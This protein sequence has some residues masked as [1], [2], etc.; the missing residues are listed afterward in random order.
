MVAGVN[1]LAEPIEEPRYT[2]L[3][4]IDN[5][6]IRRYDPVVQAVVSLP[7]SKHSARGFRRLAAFI[8]GGNNA[9]QTIAMTAPVQETQFV[10]EP[11][12]A[13]TMPAEYTLESLPEP[14][15]Q[16]IRLNEIPQR[17][18]AVIAFSGWATANKIKRYTQELQTT[19]AE[20][21]LEVTSEVM[22]NQYNP[23]W[24]P[25][26]KRRNEIM[27]E[28]NWAA[29]DIEKQPWYSSVVAEPRHI[30]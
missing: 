30:W 26:F 4:S 25:P 24:T 6:D 11:E 23:P 20:N 3:K 12:M 14:D 17:T 9:G 19:L 8:F 15:D 27:L 28:I 22:L 2:L 1:S 10:E 29:A 13:F 21:E 7:D 16:R 5:V 18:V